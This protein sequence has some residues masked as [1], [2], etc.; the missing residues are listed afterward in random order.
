MRI[1]YRFITVVSLLLVLVS[2]GSAQIF[3]GGHLG[4]RSYGLKGAYKV[5]TANGTSVGNVVDAGKTGFTVGIEGGYQILPEDVA[6]GWYKLDL[7]LEVDYTSAAFLEAG[8]NSQNGAG[9]FAADGLSKGSTS[10]FSFDIMPAHRLVIPR[11]HLLSPYA[12]L[13]LSINFMSTGDLTVDNQAQ[14]LHGTLTGNSETKLGLLVFYGV[15]LQATDMIHPY[16]QFKH[17]I[18]FGS[19]TQFTQSFQPTGG[20][21]ASNTVFSV[22]DVPGYFGITAGVR[23][24]L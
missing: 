2:F 11:F 10:I 22:Q 6:G 21:G 13:G 8:Y 24:T 18:P 5:A 12:G 23:I 20:G 14:N 16:L 7:G 1:T 17:M 19:E 15:N 4:F 9:K 3:F